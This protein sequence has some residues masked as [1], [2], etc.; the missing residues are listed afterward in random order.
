M[1][2]R[3]PSAPGATMDPMVTE[4]LTSVRSHRGA[5][6]LTLGILALVFNS[7]GALIGGVLIGVLIGVP[8]GVIAWVKAN[9]DLRDMELGVVDPSGRGLTLAG[10]VCAIV[11]LVLP[12]LFFG[13]LILFVIP[14]A[15]LGA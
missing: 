12:A 5:T 3:P 6:I 11:A 1:C 2:G 9:Q 7:V 10:K 15:T 4:A 13:L 14:A 8:L